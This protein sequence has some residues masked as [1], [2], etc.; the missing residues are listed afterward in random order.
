MAGT[1]T[2]SRA[3]VFGNMKVKFYT[4]TNYTNSETLTIDG[5]REIFMVIPETSTADKKIS[6]TVS[7]NV[8]TFATGANTYDGVMMVI[9][10]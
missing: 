10:R 1:Y 9:G 5:L 4:C 8:I 2:E 6:W 3:T 7:G